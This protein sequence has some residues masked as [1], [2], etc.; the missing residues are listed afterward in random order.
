MSITNSS[1]NPPLSKEDQQKLWLCID[2]ID[3]LNEPSRDQYILD[4]TQKKK[5]DSLVKP[6]T[7]KFTGTN[8]EI[9]QALASEVEGFE[10]VPRTVRAAV[11]V[12][13]FCVLCKRMG[14]PLVVPNLPG[15]VTDGNPE[16]LEFLGVVTKKNENKT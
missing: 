15:I 7:M 5:N 13:L 3:R 6:T 4:L 1:D 16:I 8:A 10:K 11:K 14:F 2:Q 9:M 12:L